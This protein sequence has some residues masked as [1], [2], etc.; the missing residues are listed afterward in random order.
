MAAKNKIFDFV[1]HRASKMSI[2]DNSDPSITKL[3]IFCRLDYFFLFK[4]MALIYTD[5]A[6]S[7]FVCTVDR[8]KLLEMSQYLVNK[9]F[10]RR[11]FRNNK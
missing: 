3:A 6:L 4:K 2:S 8:L 9:L 11:S 10:E 1:L 7:D 5:I